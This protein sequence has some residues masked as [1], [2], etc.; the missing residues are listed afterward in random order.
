MARGKQKFKQRDVARA[1]R[2]VQAAGL[3]VGRVDIAPDG[4]ITIRPGKPEPTET[5]SKRNEWDEVGG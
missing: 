3:E 4:T 2:A 5:E 1:I